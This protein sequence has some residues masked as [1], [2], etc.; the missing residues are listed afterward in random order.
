MEDQYKEIGQLVRKKYICNIEIRIL[1]DFFIDYTW[2]HKDL[3]LRSPDVIATRYGFS[4]L[5]TSLILTLRPGILNPD[6][7]GSI[8]NINF[9][10]KDVKFQDIYTKTLVT[11]SYDNALGCFCIP[12][13]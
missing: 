3:P 9:L 5:P 6:E 1:Y 13:G 7:Q 2:K 11:K 12:Q 10:L 8:F 4:T